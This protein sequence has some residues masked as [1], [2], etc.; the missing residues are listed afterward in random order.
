MLGIMIVSRSSRPDRIIGLYPLLISGGMLWAEQAAL[1]IRRISIIRTSLVVFAVLAFIALTPIFLP[2]LSVDATAAYTKASGISL[3]LE[4]GNRPQLFQVTA[5]RIGWEQLAKDVS[6]VYMSLPPEERE[7]T[8]VTASNY[9][10]AGAV[11]LFGSKY[12][13]PKNIICPQN[14]WYFWSD[15]SRQHSAY[16]NLGDVQPRLQEFFVEVQPALLHS[17]PYR[18]DHENNRMIFISRKPKIKLQDVWKSLKDF[19]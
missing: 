4:R 14:N 16:I 13:L 18:I 9:G 10:Q 5:D 6:K 12:P 19:M 17:A 15:I 11:D 1:K 7:N 3:E 8:V 2:V